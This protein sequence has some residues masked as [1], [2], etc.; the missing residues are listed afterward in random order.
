MKKAI[1]TLLITAISS[2]LYA[3]PGDTVEVITHSNFI[4]RTNPSAGNSGYPVWS[5]FPSEGSTFAK[6]W[7]SLDFRCPPGENCGEWDY[8]DYVFLRRKGGMNE[9]SEDIE[10][11]RF[12]TPYGNTFNS[13]WKASWEIDMTDFEQLLRDSV[14]IEY[15]HGGYETNVGR[16]WVIDLSFHF[17]EGTPS[18]D[19]VKVNRL[20]NGGFGFGNA[21]NPIN[22]QLSE[23]S[24]NMNELTR[25]LRLRINQTG[26]GADNPQ[27]CAEFC[28]MNRTLY[29]NGSSFDDH[30]VWRD[31][32]G[33]NAV[34]PQGGTWIYDRG[35]WC[36]G[37]MVFPD[38]YDFAVNPGSTETFAMEMQNYTGSG[39]AN[40]VIRTYALEFGEPNFSNDASLEDIKAPSSKYSYR[41]FNPICGRPEIVIK[42]NGKNVLN[43][44]DFSYGPL[45][46]V[47]STYTWTGSIDY[48]K[49]ETIFLPPTVQWGA[50]EGVFV[51]EVTGVNGVVDENPVN[52]KYYS[53]FEAPLVIPGDRFVVNL[54]TNNFPDENFWKILNAN[55]EEV[56]SRSNF[57]ANTEY[58]DTVDL[59]WGCYTFI[60]EDT[61]KDGLSFWAN[62][63]GA[64]FIRFRRAEAASIFKTYNGDFGTRLVVPFTLGGSL[65]ILNPIGINVFNVYPNPAKSILNIELALEDYQQVRLELVNLS[66]QLVISK[67][68]GQAKEMISQMSL[69]ELSPGIYFLHM[70]GEKVNEFRKVVIQ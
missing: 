9:V 51:T 67:D 43:S 56:M 32:C 34:F 65:G 57:E 55:G 62:D 27:F 36:P 64:G 29:R 49:T 47:M 8:L 7:V 60:L 19:L 15:I 46:G 50:E 24:F 35:N 22:D 59:S 4:I 41:R 54:K 45:G 61:D 16:G 53:D 31:D 14:E 63:D 48:M 6:A 68:L 13:T 69:D 44:I 30:L 40:Y 37:D 39:G 33:L 28:P 38:A 17:I 2:F 26:H 23:Q 21:S 12:I 3:A 52:N 70:K 11:A 20:W 58:R 42:N 10:L 66:G 25:S 5:V 1:F 18:R